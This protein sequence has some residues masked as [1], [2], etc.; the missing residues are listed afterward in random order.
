MESLPSLS[1]SNLGFVRAAVVSPELR[2]AESSSTRRRPSPRCGG[3]ARA[4]GWRSSLSWASPA[5]RARICS[6]SARCSRRRSLRWTIGRREGDIAVVVGLPIEVTA[7]CSTARRSSPTAGCWA[8]CRR[9]TCRP[10]TSSTRSAGS[11]GSLRSG[12][13]SRSTGG[14]RRSA[15]SAVCRGQSAGLVIGIEMC[16]DLWAVNPPS[17]DMALAG[18]T[19]L[20]NGS[21]SNELLGKV[22]TAATWCASSRRAAWPPISTRGRASESTTDTVW[23]GHSLIAENGAVLAE[24]ERFRFDTQMAVADVDMQRLTPSG[25]TT[26]PSASRPRPRVPHGAL[27]YAWRGA[28]VGRTSRSSGRSFRA[29][30]SCPRTRSAGGTLPGDL[31]HPVRRAGERL[32]HTGTPACHHRRVGRAGFDTGA[33]GNGESV[34]PPGLPRD[35]IIAITMPGF[36]TT[37]RTR[38]N[39]EQLAEALGVTL[40][41]IPITDAVRQHFRDIGHDESTTT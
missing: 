24:T 35:G 25:C 8:S 2:V 32:R 39:A 6:T 16:E 33:A 11:P 12:R 29:R 3:A 9:R 40:R 10:P 4:A 5:I 38:G 23:A 31:Q 37:A 27:R 18:A 36:G 30:R 15:G 1:P 26:T 7:S 19:I 28:L 21:A 13:R 17:G 22:T 20:L 14:R 34:R 41:T